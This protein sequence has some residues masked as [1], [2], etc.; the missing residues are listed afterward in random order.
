MNRR[1]IS[2][3]GFT[4]LF[5]FVSLIEATTTQIDPSEVDTLL[6]SLVREDIDQSV[7]PPPGRMID[8]GGYNLHLYSAGSGGP[9]V[10]IDG[11]IGSVSSDWNAVQTEIAKFTQVVTYDRAGL[12]WSEPSPYPRTSK[13]I[14]HEL[15]SLL[16][17]SDIPKPYI[18]VGH[19]FGGNNVQLYAA[20]YPDEVSGL[21]LVNSIHE[22][23]EKT[24]PPY[25]ISDLERLGLNC[26]GVS[27]RTPNGAEMFV[28][29]ICVALELTAFP[30]EVQIA[31]FACSL[32]RKHSYTFADEATSLT[33]SID[34]L[35]SIDRSC[36]E[37]M[38]CFVLS[39]TC[40][41]DYSKLG[42][43]FNVSKERQTIM[44][45]M[46]KSRNI[47]WDELQKSLASKFIGSHHLVAERSG[48]QIHW[49]QP[50]LIVDAV[51]KLV[52]DHS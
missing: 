9:A 3:I 23:Q 26:Q 18:L 40:D 10:I 6:H 14:V 51:K 31:H 27:F 35:A 39:A 46:Q 28:R 33:K 7:Y 47:L 17:R 11:D 50:E 34:Q 32:T 30:R 15:H 22:D 48:H 36:I 21:V 29:G 4:S 52:E 24:L 12:A 49:E 16:E 38:P 8:V 25:T 37:N 19:S 42:V 45:E 43:S 1:W 13:Q 2:N 44:D 5:L 41:I 20:T